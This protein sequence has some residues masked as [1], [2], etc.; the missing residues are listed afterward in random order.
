MAHFSDEHVLLLCGAL[1][2]ADVP[3]NLGSAN[4]PTVVVR[5]GGR[6]QRNVDETPVFALAHGLLVIDALPTT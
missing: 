2:L 5:D 4:D 3:R 1:L 6:R